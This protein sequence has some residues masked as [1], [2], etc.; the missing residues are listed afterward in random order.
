MD[1]QA[2]IAMLESIIA[3][4]GGGAVAP[5]APPPG[6]IAVSPTGP[7]GVGKTRYWPMPHPE[8][9]ELLL[10]YATRCMKVLDGT[11]KPYYQ[12]GRYGPILQG[13]PVGANMAEQLDKITYSA[14]WMTQ[15]EL[16]MAA[17]LADRDAGH[18]FSPGD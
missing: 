15:A 16:E 11:G 18:G 4:L 2:I 17:K 3:E 14:D 8:Q 10:G 9:G 7:H 12:V 1:T 6:F 5:E 13:A